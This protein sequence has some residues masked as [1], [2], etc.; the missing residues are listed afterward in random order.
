MSSETSK[1]GKGAAKKLTQEQIVAGFNQ[2]RQEQRAMASKI[3]E[4]EA[5]VNEHK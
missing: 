3:A 2:L 5:D 1:G 4:V